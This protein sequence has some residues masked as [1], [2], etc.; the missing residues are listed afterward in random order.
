MRASYA[1]RN[2]DGVLEELADVVT[3]PRS[4]R[5][6]RKPS[7]FDSPLLRGTLHQMTTHRRAFRLGIGCLLAG[8]ALA[9]FVDL[10]RV[11]W[12]LAGVVLLAALLSTAWVVDRMFPPGR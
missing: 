2:T 8:W 3:A 10:I 11:P 4:K 6:E 1:P 12:W 7:G 9:A 5:D